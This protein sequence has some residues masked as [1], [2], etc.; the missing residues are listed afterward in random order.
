M[1]T[2]TGSGRLG[3][4]IIRNLAVSFIAK[5]HDLFINYCNYDLINNLLG[6]ELFIGKNNYTNKII[7][8][9]DHTNYFDILN[10]ESIDYKF[11]P[12]DDFF[13]TIEISKMILEYLN[14]ENIRSNIINKNPFNKRYNNNNDIFIH[15]RLTDVADRNPGIKYYFKTIEKINNYENIYLSTDE[16]DHTIIKQ[17]IEKYPN[18][19]I[20]E[21]DEIKTLQFASTCKK[22]ILSHGTFSCVI[23]YLSFF[24]DV[25]YPEYDY[26]KKWHGDIF[27][28]EKWNKICYLH[29]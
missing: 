20:I 25:Y 7:K 29:P 4:Q 13:Q 12:I 19:K 9:N 18:T 22:I 5:K 23:G 11:Y 17:I 6:I 3:N 1:T 28:L 16:K 10:K 21:F 27:S 26:N 15:I 8:L 14:S 2:T 24:S